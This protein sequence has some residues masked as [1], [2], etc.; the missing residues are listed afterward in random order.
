MTTVVTLVAPPKMGQGTGRLRNSVPEIA[1]DR[2]PDFLGMRL[3]FRAIVTTMVTESGIK[4]PGRG[5]PPGP[6]RG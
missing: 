1:A 4:R 3:Q 6:T 5:K 2:F